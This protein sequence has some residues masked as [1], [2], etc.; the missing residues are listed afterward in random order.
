MDS[1]SIYWL[2]GIGVAILTVFNTVMAIGRKSGATDV[3]MARVNTNEENWQIRFDALA[4]SFTL[5]QATTSDRFERVV[6]KL[7]SGLLTM[8]KEHPTKGDLQQVKAE[9]LERID[10]QVVSLRNT[11][12]NGR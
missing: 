9:I 11:I 8:A 1:Q 6:E 5:H 12:S 10:S 3:Q 2:V 7:N 4:N